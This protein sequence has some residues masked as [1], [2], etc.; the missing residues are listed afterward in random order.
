[1]RSIPFAPG[2][3]WWLALALLSPLALF[4]QRQRAAFS[5]WILGVAGYFLVV[6]VSGPGFAPFRTPHTFIPL[7]ILAG[8]LGIDGILNALDMGMERAKG[9]RA[10]AIVIGAG[11]F[12]VC[13]VLFG[14][15]PVL[16]RF[17][18]TAA[19]SHAAQ[20]AGLDDLL[21]GE[22]AASN[23]P[24]YMIAYTRSP[25]VGI[26][27]N[28]ATAIESV[29]DRYGVRW[30]VIFSRVRMKSSGPAIARI[31]A[32]NSTTLGR[33]QLQRIP[34]EENDPAVFRVVGSSGPGPEA[35]KSWNHR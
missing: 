31:L 35:K 20:L 15:L 28:G 17:P 29:L 9:S 21:R 6:C 13:G 22:P 8:A 2:G 26:P 12:A 1:V 11:V 24:W 14:T 10:L 30:M 34:R 27:M 3:G 23:L 33:F 18:S 5:I 25:T 19:T 32:S 16:Q 7:V 4:R